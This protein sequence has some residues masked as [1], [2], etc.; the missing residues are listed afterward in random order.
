M[1]SRSNKQL[2][3]EESRKKGFKDKDVLMPKR[4]SFYRRERRGRRGN[5]ERKVISPQ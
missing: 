3:A 1:E 2:T 4:K 5:Q